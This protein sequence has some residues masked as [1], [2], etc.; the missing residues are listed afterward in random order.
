MLLGK[1][2]AYKSLTKHLT[3]KK[4][5][6]KNEMN[7]V[8]R[9]V[10][11]FEKLHWPFSNTDY[12]ELL[13]ALC[14]KGLGSKDN[15]G[16]VKVSEKLQQVLDF[17]PKDIYKTYQEV[18]NRKKSRTSFLDGLTASLLDEMNKSDE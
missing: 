6:V 5:N 7:G 1:Y 15:L 14:S 9:S 4:R 2:N 17:T 8:A 11:N 13:Y 10:T 16:I 3:F 12:V 18:K